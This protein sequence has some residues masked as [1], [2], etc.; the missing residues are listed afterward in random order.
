MSRFS[1]SIAMAVIALAAANC[2]AFRA[3]LPSVGTQK[4]PGILFIGLFPLANA[5]I[6]GLYLLASRCRISFRH[7]TPEERNGFA[8]AFVALNTLMLLA[9]VTACL[10]AESKLM[11]YLGFSL[12]PFGMLLRS[13]GLQQTDFESPFFQ[14]T[15]VPI[16]L[17][18]VVS[19]PPLLVVLVLSW[20]LSRYKFVIAPEPGPTS[21][22]TRVNE[23]SGETRSD[24][25]TA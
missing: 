22:L 12:S 10:V 3:L 15:V 17:G 7:R 20:L 21:E 6:V 14:W 4:F 25:N 2:A 19:G 5:Q 8:P 1:I 9:S 13:L 18:A 23:D 24:H 16:C 11:D